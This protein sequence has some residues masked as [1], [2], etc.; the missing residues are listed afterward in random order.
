M[1]VFES[2]LNQ[3]SWV[4]PS[5]FRVNAHVWHQR[6]YVTVHWLQS[7]LTLSL[8]HLQLT[9]TQYLQRDTATRHMQHVKCLDHNLQ[10]QHTHIS[11]VWANMAMRAGRLDRTKTFCSWQQNCP[12][13]KERVW[14]NEGSEF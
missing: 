10:K 12:D 3:C 13:I 11:I 2:P 7:S 5:C 9:T 1:A 6:S 4:R 14:S 8:W